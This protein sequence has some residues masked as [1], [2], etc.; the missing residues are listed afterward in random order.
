MKRIICTVL[1]FVLLLGL[2]LPCAHGA[3]EEESHGYLVGLPEMR[4]MSVQDV[5]AD[6][7]PLTDDVCLVDSL[8][9]VKA[10]QEAGLV[11]YYEPNYPMYLMDTQWNMSMVNAPSAWNH[12]NADGEYDRRGTGVTIAVI[13]SGVR[14]DNTDFIPGHILPYFDYYNNENGVDI[15]H[16]TFVAGLIAAQVDNGIGIDGA[17]PDVNILP[18]TITK[19]GESDT[20]V[21]IQALDYAVKQGADVINLSIGG[22]KST[23]SLEHA[24]QE[25]VDAG[26]I[27]V[28]AAGNY[29]NAADVS[30]NNI[31]YPAG[32]DC[33]VSV[34]SCKN[35]ING[36]EFDSSYSYFN[37]KVNVC[38]PGTNIKSLYF[39]M[40]TASSSGTSFATPIVSSMAAIAKQVNPA[41]TPDTFTDLVQDTATDLGDPGYDVYYG[42]GLVNMEAFC[43]ALDE[44]NPI[45]YISGEENAEFEEDVPRAYTLAD[46]DITLPTPVREGCRFVGWYDNADLL[47][48]AVIAIP[49]ASMGEK[50]FY[51]KWDEIPA[52]VIIGDVNGDGDITS[53]DSVK[54]ARYLV[55]MEE[56]SSRQLEA[57]D[58]NHDGEVTAADAVML[59]KYLVGLIDSL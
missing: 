10:M 9:D 26:V 48:D 40:G 13:D 3:V 38:A 24:C 31:I 7:T 51:A 32:Y 6:I 33:V 54:L 49:T 28:A 44:E 53:G 12:V 52:A 56:F 21:A 46:P 5:D 27:I 8:A 11:E 55:D 42:H 18:I 34:S 4:L 36:P 15:W 30:E 2:M 19:G 35:T 39:A 22:D 25:A 58:V 17:A 59:A 16:G 1:T 23:R 41:I 57:S 29:V 20:A 43:E 37:N 50:T 45:R 47:G 14:A